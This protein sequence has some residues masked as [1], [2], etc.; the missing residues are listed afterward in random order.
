MKT[1][2]LIALIVGVAAVA[3]LALCAVLGEIPNAPIWGDWVA[4]LWRTSVAF[5]VA[6]ALTLAAT[7]KA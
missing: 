3:A 6:A 4:T 5:G 7:Q 2:R 1:I